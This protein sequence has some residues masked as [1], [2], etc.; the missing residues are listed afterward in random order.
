M[1]SVCCSG[2]LFLFIG[3]CLLLVFF[4]FFSFFFSVFAVA[5]CSLLF[6]FLFAVCWLTFVILVCVDVCCLLVGGGRFLFHFVCG[7]L[8]LFVVVGCRFKSFIVICCSL[9]VVRYP[10]FVV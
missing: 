2:L 4:C 9:F 1:V 7:L 5:C 8:L 10:L 6:V 3:G